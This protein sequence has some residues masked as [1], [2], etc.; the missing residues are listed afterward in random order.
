MVYRHLPQQVVYSRLPLQVYCHLPLQ[1]YSQLPLQVYSQMPLQVYSQMPLQVYSQMPLQAG[2][3]QR[4]VKG[5]SGACPPTHSLFNSNIYLFLSR[6]T[7]G[8]V[9]WCSVLELI[10]IATCWPHQNTMLVCSHL[11]L[12]PSSLLFRYIHVRGI[13]NRGGKGTPLGRSPRNRQLRWQAQ[14][15]ERGVR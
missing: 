3:S 8:V 15:F 13:G 1:V 14:T 5:G 4:S 9:V 7:F 2:G 6:R 10:G 11:P 12:H